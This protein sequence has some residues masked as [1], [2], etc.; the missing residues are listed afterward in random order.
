MSSGLATMRIKVRGASRTILGMSL[1]T[2]SQLPL[3]RS[4]LVCP[5]FWAQPA[6]KMTRS[7][8]ERSSNLSVAVILVWG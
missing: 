3:V 6:V 4:S 5:G 2:I 8:P 1:A 7:V